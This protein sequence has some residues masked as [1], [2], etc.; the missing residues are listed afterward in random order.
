MVSGLGGFAQA[1]VE[2]DFFL[3]E[4][5][6]ANDDLREVDLRDINGSGIVLGSVSRRR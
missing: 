3:A 1:A 2:L 6:E 4:A 5:I